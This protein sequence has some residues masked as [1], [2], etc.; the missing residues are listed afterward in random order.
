MAAKKKAKAASKRVAPKRATAKVSPLKGVP[1]DVWVKTKTT[2]WH[3][4]VVTKLLA[5]ARRAAPG[6]SVSIK[7]A[8]PV[9]EQNGPFA[10]I[11]PAKAHVTFGFWR[12][13]E[14]ADPDGVLEGGDRMKHVKITSSAALDERRLE[15]FVREAVALNATRGNPT[16]R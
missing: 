10:F 16:R 1:V 2:G 7:W 14:L 3:R 9:F 5:L 11:K 6:A 15:A 12:G 8:Q 4:E 13:A